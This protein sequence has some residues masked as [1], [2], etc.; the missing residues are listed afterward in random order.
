MLSRFYVVHNS[1][2]HSQNPLHVVS[3]QFAIFETNT[4]TTIHGLIYH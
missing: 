3:I 2:S 1:C 4:N